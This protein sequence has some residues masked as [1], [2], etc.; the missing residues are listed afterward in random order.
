MSP[1]WLTALYPDSCST[2]S[3][4][5]A[6]ASKEGLNWG[7]MT[8]WKAKSNGAIL[9][10]V[11]S[12]SLLQTDQRG[13]LSLHEQQLPPK[14]IGVSVLLLQETDVPGLRL[15][16]F[17]EQTIIV[18]PVVACVLPA[19]DCGVTC[20]LIVESVDFVIVGHRWTTNIRTV[21]RIYTCT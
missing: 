18:I 7:S 3:E 12:R 4:C 1:E 17:K 20:T 13:D 10:H 19:L 15:L 16:Q 5:R 21:G 14:R 11:N 2:E 6:H 8:H 9:V